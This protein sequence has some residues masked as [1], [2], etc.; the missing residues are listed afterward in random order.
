MRSPS[1]ALHPANNWRRSCAALIDR[2]Q[3]EFKADMKGFDSQD[4][5]GVET[6]LLDAAAASPMR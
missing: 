2:Q 4:M 6:I 3:P 1:W 5:I